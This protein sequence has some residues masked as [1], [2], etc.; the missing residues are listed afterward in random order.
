MRKGKKRR[1]HRNRPSE[2]GGHSVT[3]KDVRDRHRSG[4]WRDLLKGL[5]F[6][7]LVLIIETGVEWT[8]FGKQLKLMSY[9]LLQLQLSSD[10]VPITIVDISDLEPQVFNLEGRSGKAT[11]RDSLR[12]MIEAIAD[13]EPRAI[14][15]D[16][17]FSP[18]DDGYIHPRDPE[19]FQYCLDVSKRKG[20]P[21]FLGIRRTISRPPSEWL[22]SEK[23]RGLAANILIPK[24]SKRM[25]NVIKVGDELRPGATGRSEDNGPPFGYQDKPLF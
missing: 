20:V 4:I 9:N 16:I 2:I 23:Y 1:H 18:D 15:V 21:V 22:G 5:F 3:P 24:D 10:R 11:P 7:A 6:I 13:Q 25:V 19:F 17:D 12:Q 8:T 14:G